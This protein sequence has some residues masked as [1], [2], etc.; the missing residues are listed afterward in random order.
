[1][2]LGPAIRRSTTDRRL[3][4]SSR[5]R[6]LQRCIA[7]HPVADQS[8]GVLAERLHLSPRHFTRGSVKR[9]GV[10]AGRYVGR[11]RPKTARRLLEA[12]AYG[13]ETVLLSPIPA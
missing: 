12:T 7:E 1:M 6:E 3:R 5:L 11:V 4:S 2:D 9:S 13:T 8:L 10:S